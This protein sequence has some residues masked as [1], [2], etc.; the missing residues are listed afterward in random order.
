[1]IDSSLGVVFF[2]NFNGDLIVDDFMKDFIELGKM[3]I[4]KSVDKI[5]LLSY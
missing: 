3:V 1:M 5:V 4:S 2:D